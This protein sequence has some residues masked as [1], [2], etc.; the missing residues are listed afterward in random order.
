MMQNKKINTKLQ[1]AAVF[2]LLLFACKGGSEIDIIPRQEL[3]TLQLGRL[4]DQIDLFQIAGIPDNRKNKIFMK[5]NM[6]YIANGNAS[7]VSKFT[8][9]G[10]LLFL[11]YNPEISPEPIILRQNVEN[12]MIT[13]KMAVKYNLKNIGEISVDAME[14]IYLEETIPEEQKVW[15]DNLEVMLDSR[16]LKFNSKGQLLDIYGKEGVGNSL[17]PYINSMHINSAAELIVICRTPLSWLIYWFT[18]A[19]RIKYS[20][21]I[22]QHNIPAVNNN[23]ALVSYASID[24]ILPDYE[25]E[26]L[27]LQITHYVEVL[28]TATNTKANIVNENSRIYTLNVES[29]KYEKFIKAPESGKRK[30]YSNTG[31]MEIAAPP[32]EFLG[33]AGSYYYFIRPEENNRSQVLVYNSAG[34]KYLSRFLVIEEGEL[35]YKQISMTE[36]GLIY[37]LLCFKNRVDFVWWR[38][39]KLLGDNVQ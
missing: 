11:L 15:D 36:K 20:I 28:D 18:K 35:Y 10:D 21:V 33:T 5:D 26:L 31:E 24:K 17:F 2:A 13:S 38:I 8:S 19:G 6:F 9:F 4:E 14:N 7:K 27:Y 3:F 39:D 34:K 16:I 22:D 29:K 30:F 1:L 32:F 12:D 23:P 37:G 25:K